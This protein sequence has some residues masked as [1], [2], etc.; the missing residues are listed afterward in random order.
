MWKNLN[1]AR[2]DIIEG[3]ESVPSSAKAFLEDLTSDMDELKGA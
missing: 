3:V 2:V 1:K